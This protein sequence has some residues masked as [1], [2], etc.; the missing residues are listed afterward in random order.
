MYQPSLFEQVSLDPTNRVKSAMREALKECRL[1]REQVV[2][3]IN[4]LAGVEG[5]KT[6]VS[7]SLLDKWV[8][9]SANHLIPWKLLPIFCQVTKS[10]LPLQALVAPLGLQVI[11]PSEIK[12][13]EWGKVELQRRA[14]SKKTR[15]LMEEIK[16]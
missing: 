9:A 7:L 3:E 14:L 2:D 16:V 12:I 4:R 1:S 13:L 15:R 11:G 5:I 6:K 8:A 10:I